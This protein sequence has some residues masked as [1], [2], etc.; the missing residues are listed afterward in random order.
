MEEN[1]EECSTIS[2]FKHLSLRH[3]Q[4]TSQL[5]LALLELQILVNF[6]FNVIY[7][8]VSK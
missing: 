5:Y 4:L 1:Q 8:S 7:L 3:P 2:M 6:F